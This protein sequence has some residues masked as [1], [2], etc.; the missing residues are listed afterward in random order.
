MHEQIKY[1][2]QQYLEDSLRPYNHYLP[3]GPT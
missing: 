1:Y 2:K 3:N